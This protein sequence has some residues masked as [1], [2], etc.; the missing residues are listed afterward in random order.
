MWILK[1]AFQGGF[2]LLPVL[3]SVTIYGCSDESEKRA[4]EDRLITATVQPSPTPAPTLTPTAAPYSVSDPA[5]GFGPVHIE[6]L[7]VTGNETWYPRQLIPGSRLFLVFKPPDFLG[8]EACQ[9]PPPDPENPGRMGLWDI[10]TGTVDEFRTLEP[11]RQLPA[12]GSDGHFLVWAEGCAHGMIGGWWLYAMDV[13]TKEWWHVDTDFSTVTGDPSLDNCAFSL[14][15]DDGRLVYSTAVANLSGRY[16][17]EMRTYDLAARA[18][19]V[20]SLSGEVPSVHIGCS[21]CGT[22]RE[23]LVAGHMWPLRLDGARLIWTGPRLVDY[24]PCPVQDCNQLRGLYSTD[25]STGETDAL[26]AEGMLD[27]GQILSLFTGS[28]QG[29]RAGSS[30]WAEFIQL[31][32][33]LLLWVNRPEGDAMAFDTDSRRLIKLSD[34]VVTSLFADDDS[35]YWA[36]GG[37]L[38]WVDLP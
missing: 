8:C 12:S 29:R 6:R 30:R 4:E 20:L 27:S 16:V 38:H 35:V 34:C 9:F 14:A 10:D 17:W 28:A 3:L 36:C 1:R 21:D 2:L 24:Q 7:P 18:G 32:P 33:G 25:I 13:S 26:I 22:S 5:V 37:N 23:G 19:S 11:G 15:V 31:V